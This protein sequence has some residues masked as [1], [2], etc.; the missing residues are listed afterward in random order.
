MNLWLFGW[1]FV[2]LDLVTPPNDEELFMHM[3]IGE[4]VC[5]I[6]CG[7]VDRGV[8]ACVSAAIGLKLIRIRWNFS[9][10][11]KIYINRFCIQHE[12]TSAKQKR[13]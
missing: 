7:A 2:E 1:R 6:G 3:R 9:M 5:D 13:I 8:S 4:W 12:R 10:N 11:A